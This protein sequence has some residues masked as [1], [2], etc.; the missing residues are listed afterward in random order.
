MTFLEFLAA[1]VP[2]LLATVVG[3]L[4]AVYAARLAFNWEQGA[5]RQNDVERVAESL[6]QRIG[7]YVVAAEAY[8]REFA[9]IDWRQGQKPQ[10]TMPHPA[11]VSI[12][13]EMLRVRTSGDD[14]EIAD[15]IGRTWDAVAHAPLDNVATA[16]GVLAGAIASWR[17]GVPRARVMDSLETARQLS[18]ASGEF[19]VSPDD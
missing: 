6:M 8:R 11:G 7:D 12:E 10:R 4:L 14:A 18:L 1:F 16:C 19:D 3:G 5:E 2:Q 13:V 9:L 17:R 15:E